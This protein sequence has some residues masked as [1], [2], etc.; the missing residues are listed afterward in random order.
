VVSSTT[1]NDRS[2]S[3]PVAPA[4]FLF[5]L[6]V[7][8]GASASIAQQRP[9]GQPSQAVATNAP[10]STT[11]L[12]LVWSA[13]AAVDHA[14]QTGNYSVLRDLGAPSFQA[15]NNAASLAGVFSALRAQRTDLSN[16][17]VVTPSFEFAPTIIQGGLLRIRGSFPLRPNPIGFDLLYQNVSGQ[18]RLFGIAVAPLAAQAP[19]R[20]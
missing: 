10:D 7:A 15:N 13:M 5:G 19:V 4:R 17:L 18:W 6:L 8:L 3:G 11:V 20:R 1:G 16:V 9:Q 12:K 14:N 2:G